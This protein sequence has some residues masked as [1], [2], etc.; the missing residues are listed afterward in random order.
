ML[1]N[2]HNFQTPI[3]PFSNGKS[4]LAEIIFNEQSMFEKHDG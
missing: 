4:V 3:F 1:H 2:P